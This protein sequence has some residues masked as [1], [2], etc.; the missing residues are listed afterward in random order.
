MGGALTPLLVVWIEQRYSWRMAFA[1]FGLVGVFWAALWYAWF[2]NSPWEMAAVPAA[3]RERIG[4]PPAP[5]EARV[6]WSRLLRNRNFQRILVMYHAYCWGAYFYLSWLHTYLQ[7]GRGLTED[8]MKIASSVPFWAGLLGILAG[9]YGSDL[10]SRRYSLRVARCGIGSVALL[11][12]GVCLLA[13]T[14]CANI[15]WVVGLLTIGLGVMTASLPV[16]WSV[17][18]DV[19]QE[20]AGTISGA[21]N[22]AGQAGSLISSVA[23]GYLVEWLGSYDRALVPLGA[24]LLVGGVTFALI[25]P[26]EKVLEGEPRAALAIQE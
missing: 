8:Q 4:H 22:M 2:R 23:F 13:A 24:M 15:A 18:V 6:P 9:G 10:L 16:S 7:V 17:C 12:S 26:A 5:R 21:M 25:D 3:E 19:G 20:H 1:L 14:V 11:A